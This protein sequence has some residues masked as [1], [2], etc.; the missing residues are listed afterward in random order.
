MIRHSNRCLGART[1]STR[2]LFVTL[3]GGAYSR[4]AHC[5]GDFSELGVGHGRT[6]T[7]FC[8]GGGSLGT[9]FSGCCGSG[10]CSSTIRGNTICGYRLSD[11]RHVTNSGRPC[12]I[13]F[14]SALAVRDMSKRGLGFLVHAENR[15]IE[16]AP[17]FPRGIAKFFFDRFLRRVVQVRRP[18]GR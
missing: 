10:T 17:R 15:L 1:R 16:A 3:I 5:T 6:R 12:R 13:R 4:T 8:V 11:I 14:S 7:T 9:V 18:L 2:S